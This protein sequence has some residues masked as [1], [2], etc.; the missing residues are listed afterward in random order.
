[1]HPRNLMLEGASTSQIS[2]FAL[3][4]WVPWLNRVVS[5]LVRSINFVSRQGLWYG[6]NYS[7]G[8]N[9]NESDMIRSEPQSEYHRGRDNWALLYCLPRPS[10][11]LFSHLFLSPRVPL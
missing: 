8:L 11:L 6:T 10:G 3:W 2:S 4:T 7:T 5:S 1:M 9:V